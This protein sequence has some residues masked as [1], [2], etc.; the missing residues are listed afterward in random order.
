LAAL[1]ARGADVNASNDNGGTPLMYA[2]IP[3]TVA[4]VEL[5]LANGSTLDATGRNGWTALMIATAKAHTEV[6]A[7]LLAHGADPDKADIYG[8]TPLMRAAWEDRPA[9]VRA[10]LNAP[11]IG[12]NERDDQGATAL[13]HAASKGSLEMVRMLVEH[14]AIPGTRDDAGRTAA[15]RA[16]L[17]EHAAV[18]E[19][20]T[21]GTGRNS[22]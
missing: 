4:G 3:G 9:V 22:K 16:A 21:C 1:I 20:L 6:V 15:D 13:H 7:L 18:V 5:L 2:A 19:I 12:V 17:M 11:G 8:W 14:G 10:L